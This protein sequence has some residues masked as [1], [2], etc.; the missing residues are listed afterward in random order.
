MRKVTI[1]LD[2]TLWR[3]FRIGC[4]EHETTAAH[5]LAQLIAAELA[6]WAQERTTDHDHHDAT[7]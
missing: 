7:P 1:V 5:H 4:L 2:E 6:H 3:Q